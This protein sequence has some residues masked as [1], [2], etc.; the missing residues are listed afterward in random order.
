MTYEKTNQSDRQIGV[1]AIILAAFFLISS[2]GLLEYSILDNG[3]NT[4]LS[5]GLVAYGV[6]MITKCDY[7]LDTRPNQ[8]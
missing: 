6:Y 5:F 1:V 7:I 2:M 8:D 4:L 3:V